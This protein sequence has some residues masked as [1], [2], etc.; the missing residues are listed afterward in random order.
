M[1]NNFILKTIGTPGPRVGGIMWV[2]SSFVYLFGGQSFLSSSS[3]PSLSLGEPMNDVWRLS[4]IENVWRWMEGGERDEERRG[5]GMNF[6]RRRSG[7]SFYTDGTMMWTF[8]GYSDSAKTSIIIIRVINT[9]III[10]NSLLQL[11]TNNLIIN[12]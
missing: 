2:S 9:I 12:Y 3:F 4:T 7:A 10:I 8:G 11:S 6:P 5:G 1:I